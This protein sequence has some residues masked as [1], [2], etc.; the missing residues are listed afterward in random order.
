MIGKVAVA[1]L[2][3]AFPII[4]IGDCGR[5]L[6]SMCWY[7]GV[8][9]IG[10]IIHDWVNKDNFFHLG[11]IGDQG[12][13]CRGWLQPSRWCGLRYIGTRTGLE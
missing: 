13:L 8:V 10:I 5:D 2:G 11:S 7:G 3:G 12:F 1:L 4:D 9:S 6:S